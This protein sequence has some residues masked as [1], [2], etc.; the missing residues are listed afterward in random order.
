M[1]NALSAVFPGSFDPFTNGH[2]DIL[3]RACVLFESV[4]VLVS[5][6]DDKKYMFSDEKRL[7][8][9]NASIADIKNAKA[10]LFSGYISEYACRNN[11]DIIVKGLRNG[12]DFGYEKKMADVNCAIALEKFGRP[13]ET[14]YLQSK[15]EFS[16]LSSSAVKKLISEGYDF[17]KFVPCVKLIKE[18]LGF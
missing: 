16:L 12:E 7:K 15:D 6:N 8:I 14:V 1:K 13:L 17:D 3:K 9:V 2:L 18:M 4:T 5:K 11:I 10:D